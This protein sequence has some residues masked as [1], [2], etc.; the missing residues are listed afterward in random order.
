MARGNLSACLDITLKHE[1]GY[2]D[3]PAD[4]GG[5]TN[6][7]ITHKVL[8]K[9]RGISPWWALDKKEIKALRLVE[10][11]S[12]Y[13]K[14]YWQPINAELLPYGVDL[15]TF[16]SAVNSGPS[17]GAKWLQRAAGV[18]QDGVVG[19]ATL[20]SVAA[21]DGD[22]IVRLMCGYRL[23]FVQSLGTFKVFGSGWSRRIAD[24]EA[25]GVAM[26]LRNGAGKS[27]GQ[28]ADQMAREAEAAAGKAADQGRGAATGGVGGVL[29]GGS[30]I[31][32]G[33]TLW[34]LVVGGVLLLV[35]IGLVIKSRQNAARAAAYGR[36]LDVQALDELAGQ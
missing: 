13:D 18:K 15:A 10:A 9:W 19:Q 25:K 31:A 6:M 34:L 4:P 5:A 35:A 7:G 29:A 11:T 27:A 8:A 23:S 24:I 28:V 14:N 22:K 2:V 21:D 17:R 1:G 30:D 20:R 16:D 36:E 33:G 3:H 12:I 32:A 26:W